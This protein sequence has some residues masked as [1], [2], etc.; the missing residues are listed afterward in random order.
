MQKLAYRWQQ[1]MTSQL[2]D[3][4]APPEIIEEWKIGGTVG[5]VNYIFTQQL[6]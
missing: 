6:W 3:P 1:N 5:S 4:S 2:T